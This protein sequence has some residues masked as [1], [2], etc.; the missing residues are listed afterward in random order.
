M[1]GEGAVD[2]VDRTFRPGQSRKLVSGR[3]VLSFGL[4]FSDPGET[5]SP[6]IV[7]FREIEMAHI[8]ARIAQECLHAPGSL[9][10]GGHTIYGP[11]LQL[12]V[13]LGAMRN[14]LETS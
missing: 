14:D 7:P 9:R 8:A 11:N 4:P 13:L 3:C 5:T 1:S 10:F 2:L 12:H 6:M